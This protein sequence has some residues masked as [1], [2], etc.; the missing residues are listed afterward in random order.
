L[1]PG[2]SSRNTYADAPVLDRRDR[3]HQ[4]PREHE[5]ACRPASMGHVLFARAGPSSL[6]IPAL[7][8]C[9]M[10]S[11]FQLIFWRR[12]IPRIVWIRPTA[13]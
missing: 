4:S 10:C 9:E 6:K 7:T 13:W 11:M 5:G 3:Y 12:R 1:S 2:T 8:M